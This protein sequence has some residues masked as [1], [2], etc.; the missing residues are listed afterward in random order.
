V[1]GLQLGAVDYLS[2]PFDFEEVC[3][4]LNA[5]L[6][7]YH[8]HQQIEELLAQREQAEASERQQRLFVKALLDS[9]IALSSTL[10]LDE[11]LQRI[12]LDV[13][14]VVPHDMALIVLVEHDQA[15]V[16]SF[17]STLPNRW[18]VPPGKIPVSEIGIIQTMR[19]TRRPHIIADTQITPLWLELSDQG[20]LRSFIAAPIFADDKLIGTLNL[21]ALPPDFYSESAA[22]RLQ[23]FAL[24]ASFALKNARLYEH[25]QELAVVQERERLARE[26][27]DS[28]SQTLFSANAIAETL[29]R[30][31]T[32][33]TE[34]GRRYMNDLTQLTREAMAEMRSL[35]FELRPEVLT[36]SELGI[37]IKQLCDIFAL[38][39]RLPVV[40]RS[41]D[42]LMMVAEQQVTYYRVAQEA[43]NN[44]DRHAQAT[45][46]EI[47]LERQPDGN[48]E[49]RV[50]DNG[51]GFDPQSVPPHRTGLNMMRERAE[52]IGAE[53]IITSQPGHGTQVLLRGTA[54]DRS[55]S[56]SR[57]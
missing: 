19:D 15:W 35:M 1:K 49:L 41:P 10:D 12:L 9:A 25:A 11:I 37:L 30:I 28:V 42:K 31:I 52:S 16:A 23:A 40:F 26:L 50:R 34:K 4:R 45:E 6:T 48:L 21:L 36:N 18:R 53:L 20:A 47:S 32:P 51:I 46:V 33:D 14:L 2:K 27:H 8:Q 5:H 29:P 13:G 57:R 17:H 43:L 55:N 22:E 7:L 56:N 38:K 3:A 54:Y 44:I 24:L 39:T